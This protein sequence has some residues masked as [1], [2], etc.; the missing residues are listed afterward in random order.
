MNLN[1]I[2]V[3]VSYETNVLWFAYSLDAVSSSGYAVYFHEFLNE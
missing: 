2:S 3:T 1:S